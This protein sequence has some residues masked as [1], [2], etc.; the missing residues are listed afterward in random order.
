MI[1]SNGNSRIRNIIQLN[2]SSKARHEQKVFTAEGI[3]MFMEAPCLRIREV[4]VSEELESKITDVIQGRAGHVDKDGSKDMESMIKLSDKLSKIQYETVSSNVFKHMADT[5]TPQGIITVIEAEKRDTAKIL[6]LH[7]GGDLH[8]LILEGIQDP[9]N[10]GTMLRTAEGAGYDFILADRNTADVYNPKVIR[11]TMG[12]IFRVPVIYSSNLLKDIE[13]LKNAGIRIY[14]AHLKGEKTYD[15]AEYPGRMAVMIG[16][17]GR[18]L[19]D[20]ITNM[21]DEC[22]RIPMKGQVESLN[23]AVAAA[24]LMFGSSRA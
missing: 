9:G 7:D 19:S 15:E 22:I 16:N 1:T 8:I 13:G 23:A 2:N 12:S 21:A 18:G 11:S 3:K 20:D 17:E 4:F 24:L 10:L 5:V 6:E 14:A